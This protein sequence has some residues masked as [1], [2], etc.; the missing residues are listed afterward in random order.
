MG[1]S[2]STH[3]NSEN[4]SPIL[5]RFVVRPLLFFEHSKKVV[6]FQYF[7]PETVMDWKF[8]GKRNYNSATFRYLTVTFVGSCH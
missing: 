4:V 2:S 1:D 8:D 6:F 5:L 3:T 7:E